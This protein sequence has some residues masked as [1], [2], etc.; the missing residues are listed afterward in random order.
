MSTSRCRQARGKLRPVVARRL[1]RSRRGP[2]TTRGPS[3]VGTMVR[4]A[5]RPPPPA[6]RRSSCSPQ[7]DPSGCSRTRWPR[8]PVPAH[9]VRWQVSSN[10]MASRGR[11]PAAATNGASSAVGAPPSACTSAS[12]AAAS[13]SATMAAALALHRHVL[14]HWVAIEEGQLL[15]VRRLRLELRHRLDPAAE[16]VA[17]AQRCRSA[18]GKSALR[19]PNRARCCASRASRGRVHR[20]GGRRP[21]ADA[22]DVVA[23]PSSYG[24]RFCGVRWPTFARGCEVQQRRRSAAAKS[25][26]EHDAHHGRGTRAAT[27]KFPTRKRSPQNAPDYRLILARASKGGGGD[28]ASH[29]PAGATFS[30]RPRWP[31]RSYAR[32]GRSAG[33]RGRL[34]RPAAGA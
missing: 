4:A 17:P 12:L 29:P 23:T 1:P 24:A 11:E 9:G 8:W 26:R 27:K 30:S 33:S 16:V 5:C 32:G 18:S 14:E 19:A 22:G 6:T 7:A 34:R 21:T 13:S 15:L 31:A 10:T 25:V 28:R 2:R 3:R 20:A